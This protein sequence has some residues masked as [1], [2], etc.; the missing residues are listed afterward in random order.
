MTPICIAK[1]AHA[2]NAAY[3]QSQGD[4][5][6]KPWEQAPEWQKTSAVN[7]VLFHLENPDA[8]PSHSHDSWMKE[9]IE[10]GWVYGTEK[11][12]EKKTH[13]CIVPYAE[14]PPQQQA[15]DYIFRAVVHAP[16]NLD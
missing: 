9:K 1:V 14:L 12:E 11:D 10:A 7:G 8:G 6:Q 16:A 2:V 3:C 4:M 5:S 15:K 13:P